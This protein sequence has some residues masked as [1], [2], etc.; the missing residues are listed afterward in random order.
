[1]PSFRGIELSF[2]IITC[3][4]NPERHI[5]LVSTPFRLKLCNVGHVVGPSG[6]PA[7]EINGFSFDDTVPVHFVLGSWASWGVW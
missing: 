3:L 1:M 2:E 7:G 6:W 4:G 5:S